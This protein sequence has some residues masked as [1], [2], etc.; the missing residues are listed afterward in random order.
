MIDD[1]AA[2][3][4]AAEYKQASKKVRIRKKPKVKKGRKRAA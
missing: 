2:K 4:L 1:K 3:M